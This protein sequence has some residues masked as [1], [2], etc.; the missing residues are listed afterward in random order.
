[1]IKGQETDL[2]FETPCSRLRI[3]TSLGISGNDLL[4]LFLLSLQVV[5]F[6]K[7]STKVGGEACETPP[8][9]RFCRKLMVAG[10][11]ERFSSVV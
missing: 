8:H 10:E 9:P 5:R 11:G 2:M 1:M 7:N 3:A 4:F 6:L